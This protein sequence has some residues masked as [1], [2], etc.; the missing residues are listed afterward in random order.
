MKCILVGTEHGV[1]E[2]GLMICDINLMSVHMSCRGCAQ[3]PARSLSLA[4]GVSVIAHHRYTPYKQ[5]RN[6][7]CEYASFLPRCKY[8]ESCDKK[9]V[10]GLDW[11]ERLMNECP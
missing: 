1:T 10:G 8:P 4:S 3:T 6:L 5:A 9:K 2:Y 11:L 7:V